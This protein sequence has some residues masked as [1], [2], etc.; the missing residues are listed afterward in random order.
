MRH[1]ITQIQQNKRNM[2][3]LKKYSD[4]LAWELMLNKEIKLDEIKQRLN[5]LIEL[6]KNEG[7]M[8]LNPNLKI[9]EVNL[10]DN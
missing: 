2:S 5:T 8:E 1:K 3:H 7:K 10:F 6:A 4:E 9:D